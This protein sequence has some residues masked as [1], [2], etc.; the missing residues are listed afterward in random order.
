MTDDERREQAIRALMRE[1]RVSAAMAQS[2]YAVDSG[3]APG[4]VAYERDGEVVAEVSPV[5]IGQQGQMLTKK[6][7]CA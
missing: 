5:P 2:I 7:V 3:E 4:D 6:A 1:Q